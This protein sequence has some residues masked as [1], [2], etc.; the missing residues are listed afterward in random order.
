V[1]IVLALIPLT[2]GRPQAQELVGA[3]FVLVVVLTLVQGG[4]LPVL[5]KLLGLTGSVRQDELEID[6]APL[7]ELGAE[8]IQVRVQPGS[9]LHGVYLN[10]LRLPIGA[11][12]SL[13][14]REDAGFTPN[15]RTRLREGDQLLVVTT[16]EV[17]DIAERRIRAVDRGGRYARWKGTTDT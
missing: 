15:G 4:T 16:D 10:E 12:I 7:D 1:P 11:T 9:R 6:S 17:R 8:L 5:A 14:V 13:V 2:D 3:V